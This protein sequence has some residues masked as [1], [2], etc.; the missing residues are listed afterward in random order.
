M[1]PA[2]KSSGATEPPPLPAHQSMSDQV[3]EREPQVPGPHFARRMAARIYVAAL[4][5]AL[6]TTLLGW[7][8]FLGW[9]VYRLF[10]S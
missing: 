6:G 2:K 4:L 7:L 9:G 8:T 10:L 1:S 5:A 3:K